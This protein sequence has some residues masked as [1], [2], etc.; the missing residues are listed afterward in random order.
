MYIHTYIYIS[1]YIYIYIY[2]Y[3]HIYVYT[4]IY[5]SPQ[6]TESAS[7]Q[8]R[9]REFEAS[10]RVESN[11]S[12]GILKSQQCDEYVAGSCR[13]LQFVAVCCS[14]IVPH[15]AQEISCIVLQYA[16]VCCSVLQCVTVCCRVSHTYIHTHTQIHILHIHTR[17]RTRT[18]THTYTRTCT[19]THTHTYTHSHTHDTHT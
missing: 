16:A 9:E 5:F 12:W 6:A 3:T 8:W 7:E 19:Q 14:A 4:Y 11:N 10:T 17:T 1:V 18:Q 15:N 13:V 2:I